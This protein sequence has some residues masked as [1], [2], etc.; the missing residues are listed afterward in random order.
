[1]PNST[2]VFPSRYNVQSLKHVDPRFFAAKDIVIAMVRRDNS[3]IPPENAIIVPVLKRIE[4]VTLRNVQP[5]QT[6][7]RPEETSPRPRIPG[8]I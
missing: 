3:Y 1:M 2:A 5:L 7:Q 6:I 8:R 4:K